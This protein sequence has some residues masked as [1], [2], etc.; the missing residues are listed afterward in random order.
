[1]CI[2]GFIAKLELL[3]GESGDKY[4]SEQADA[5]EVGLGHSQSASIVSSKTGR[6]AAH[7]LFGEPFYNSV[8]YLVPHAPEFV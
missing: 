5:R 1:M 8:T 4:G 6:W 7:G 3:L 2:L